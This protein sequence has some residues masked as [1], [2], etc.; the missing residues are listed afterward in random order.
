MAADPDR[1]MVATDT[2][3]GLTGMAFV[4]KKLFTKEDPQMLHKVRPPP[5]PPQSHQIPAVFFCLECKFFT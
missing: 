2:A 4:I 3:K 5:P 1:E